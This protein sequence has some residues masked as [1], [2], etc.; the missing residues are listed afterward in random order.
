MKKTIT[1]AHGNGGKLT[2]DLIQKSFLPLLSNEHL[3]SLGDS[4][5]LDSEEG[6]LAFTT[7]SYVVNPVFFPGGDIGRLAV[8]GT[9]NDLTVMGAS[10]RFLSLAFILEEGFPEEDLNRIL[11]SIRDTANEASVRIV[12]GD[13]KVVGKG[14]ADGIFVNTSGVGFIDPRLPAFSAD[15]I[16]P[17]D[18]VICTGT[19]G[20]HGMAIFTA[21]NDFP[22]RSNLVSDCAP[23]N[24]LLSPLFK[25]DFAESVRIVR[26]P[27]RGGLATV[28]NEFVQGKP[29]GIMLHE[30]AV[31]VRDEVTVLCEMSGYDPLYVANEGKAVLV[32]SGQS[33]DGI[34][35]LLK[36][37]P[38]GRDACIVGEVDGSL[39]GKVIL[40]TRS[41][42]KR[43]VDMLYG[44]MLPRIC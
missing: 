28:L 35:N 5:V 34:L 4:A 10:P 1:L 24:G 21:R 13:T 37:H 43:I 31:P 20:D 25:S 29:L 7:D 14:S 22:L 38:L 36:A 16:S 11:K 27:T 42:G 15:L 18:K 32:V 8:C 19:I 39:D 2:H 26:D 12:T 30:E 23:L 44:E 40:R 33:A 9:V 41:G 3:D 6:R 17:G